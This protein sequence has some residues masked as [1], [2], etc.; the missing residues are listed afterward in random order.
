MYIRQPS[1][2]WRGVAFQMSLNYVGR[3]ERDYRLMTCGPPYQIGPA[4][5]CHDF[6]HGDVVGLVDGIGR[7]HGPDKI[8]RPV[9]R[10]QCAKQPP[11][12]GRDDNAISVQGSLHPPPHS[13]GGVIPA[14][15]SRYPN[16][17]VRDGAVLVKPLF[18]MA[19]A[20]TVRVFSLGISVVERIPVHVG[21]F[22]R[23][24]GEKIEMSIQIDRASADEQ[25]AANVALECLHRR[26]NVLRAVRLSVYDGIE[27][28]AFQFAVEVLSVIAITLNMLDLIPPVRPCIAAREHRYMIALIQKFLHHNTAHVARSTD[29]QDVH[30]HS[31]LAR[32][33]MGNVPSISQFKSLGFVPGEG[34]E[35]APS[36]YR[37][38]SITV[39]ISVNM[40]RPKCRDS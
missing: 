17:G 28:L 20:D 16:D 24:V 26:Y 38:K 29:N 4:L 35:E 13:L 7:L 10:V 37:T 12:F 2:Q 30:C 25:V 9:G 36:Q 14:H 40:K 33:L 3:Y 22:E 27:G 23:A 31:L 34:S 6:L 1:A 21:L 15:D 32:I 19:L 11:I 18:A 5:D 39:S 8:S